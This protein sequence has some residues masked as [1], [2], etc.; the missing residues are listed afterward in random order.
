[1]AVVQWWWCGAMVVVWCDGGG[2]VQWWWCGYS[3]GVV[4]AVM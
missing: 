1:M 4:I 3:Y 2:V